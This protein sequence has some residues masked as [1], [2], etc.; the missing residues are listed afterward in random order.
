MQ[1]FHPTITQTEKSTLSR[2][3]FLCVGEVIGDKFIP[4]EACIQADT[5]EAQESVQAF[6]AAHGLNGGYTD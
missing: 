4:T 2:I 5:L 1:C 3:G 6:L